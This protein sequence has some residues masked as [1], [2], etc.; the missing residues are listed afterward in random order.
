MLVEQKG[1]SPGIILYYMKCLL[2]H[3]KAESAV[4]FLRLTVLVLPMF[5]LPIQV[6]P[7]LCFITI[8]AVL[9]FLKCLIVNINAESA[10]GFLQLPVLALPMMVLPALCFITIIAVIVELKGGSPGITLYYM[11][12]LIVHTKAE[13]AEDFL[14]LTC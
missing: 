14:Q 7:A 11:K 13:S 8:I 9:Y 5:V 1:G 3:T 10:K 4:D 6:L 2:V 12:C